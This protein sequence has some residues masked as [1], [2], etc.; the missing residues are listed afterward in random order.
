[1]AGGGLRT[2]PAVLA[3]Q[4][5]VRGGQTLLVYEDDDGETIALTYADVWASAQAAAELLR[6]RGVGVGD[7]VHLNLR[8]CPE[9]VVLLV[10]AG[11]LG[12]VVVPT[13]PN[14]VVGE[15]AFVIRHARVKLSIAEPDRLDVVEAADAGSGRAPLSRTEVP[16]VRAR[17]EDAARPADLA[18]ASPLDALA[19][20]YTSGTTSHPKGVL[21]T[22]ASYVHVGTAVARHLRVTPTDRWLVVLPMFHANAQ[23]YCVM[24]ALVAGASVALMSRFSASRWARQASRHGATLA[25][26][27]AAP[28]RMLLAQAPRAD[29]AENALRLTVF[30]Q[31]VGD[32]Q[33]ATFEQRFACPLLQLYGMTETIAPPLMNP[34]DG[35]RRNETVGRPIAGARVRIVDEAGDDAE[36]GELLVAGVPGVSLMAGYVDDADATSEALAD[37]WLRTGDMMRVAGEGW[38]AFHDRVKDMIKSSGE[39]IAAAEVERVIDSHPAVFESAVVGLPDPVRDEVVQAFVV[40]HEGAPLA[41]QELIDWCAQRLVRFKVP[42]DVQIVAELPRTSVGKV[43]KH[44]LRATA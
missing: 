13:N 36:V 25:S 29:D 12:A 43:Q 16:I 20:L 33:L 39:N 2:V 6:A 23:Y 17:A 27:F 9:F 15:L 41:A 21:V 14:A 35:P 18:A 40:L 26:L 24:S 42:A 32:D 10:A 3:E 44:R 5:A 22:H 8:N 37:G 30:A 34:L 38:Y 28:I 1:M 11:L 4:A 31:R 19:V 7:R